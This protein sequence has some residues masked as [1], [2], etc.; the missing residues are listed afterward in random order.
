L[1]RMAF[2]DPRAR[3]LARREQELLQAHGDA[4]R[5]ELP[6]LDGVSW[7]DFRR[8]FVEAV[9][10]ADVPTFFRQT[11]AL[12]AT[13]PIREVR[14]LRA[15]VQDVEALARSHHLERLTTLGLSDNPLGPE[16]ARVIAWSPHLARLRTLL[17]C[18]DQL[19]DTAGRVVSERLSC[20]TELFLAG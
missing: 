15:T 13:A 14:F 3:V 6:V 7:G 11:L 12:F 19:R 18:N 16:V 20:L 8:G 17:M 1:A 4:W 9:R 5:A 10:G 2:A